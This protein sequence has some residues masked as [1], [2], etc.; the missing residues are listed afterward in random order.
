MSKNVR[1]IS[2]PDALIAQEYLGNGKYV[3]RMVKGITTDKYDSGLK[4]TRLGVPVDLNFYIETIVKNAFD[5]DGKI[6]MVYDGY[7][8]FKAVSNLKQAMYYAQ[9]PTVKHMILNSFYKSEE[10]EE[11]NLRHIEW[12]AFDFELIK[13][14]G[15]TFIAGEVYAIF[16]NIG[17]PPT[18]IK[19][20]KSNLYHVL[21]QHTPITGHE[22]PVDLHKK[23][24]KMIGQKIG[25]PEQAIGP[26]HPFSLHDKDI[27][28]FEGNL[29]DFES[30]KQWY[31]KECGIQ[32]SK[33]I[34]DDEGKILSFTEAMIWRSQA[35]QNLVNCDFDTSHSRAKVAFTIALLYKALRKPRDEAYE[36]LMTWKDSANKMKQHKIDPS[37]IRK[38]V[39][40]AYDKEFWGPSR[41]KIEEYSGEPFQF[42]LYHRYRYER[43][44]NNNSAEDNRNAILDYFRANNGVIE[45]MLKK[46]L[47]NT[48]AGEEYAPTSIKRHLDAMKKKGV[49]DWETTKGGYGGGANKVTFRLLENE[50]SKLRNMES[51]TV[52]EFEGKIH[53]LRAN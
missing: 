48:I 46:D 40:S 36:F 41:E 25:Y 10:R 12:M 32:Y 43:K 49:I 1:F 8:K 21:I 11:K 47:I 13:S 6:M 44:T 20:S 9:F 45:G 3:S 17:F 15:A 39:R 52:V 26:A 34:N 5:K 23:I 7:Y 22:K 18:F 51:E 28:Y 33:P 30:M 53:I 50:L 2:Y 27:R 4:I 14:N 29:V 35:I 38:A 31:L 16:A 42:N 24:Q 37:E 19:R